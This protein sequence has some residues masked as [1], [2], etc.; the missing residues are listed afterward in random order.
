MRSSPLKIIIENSQD[1]IKISSEIKKLLKACASST[2]RRIDFKAPAIINIIIEDA[3]QVHKLNKEY[4]NIDRATDELSFPL[5]EFINGLMD[6][7]PGDIDIE[8]KLLITVAPDGFLKR[9]K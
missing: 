1:R 7:H 8:N 6:V 2:A 4:R 9:I 3:N 5:V